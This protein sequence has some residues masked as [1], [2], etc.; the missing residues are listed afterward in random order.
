[1][2]AREE[3]EPLARA[4]HARVDA[5][6]SPHLARRG[7]GVKHPV[8]DFLFGYYSFR[9]A[10]LRRWHPGYGVGL[11][12]VEDAGRGYETVGGVTRVA[13]TVLDSLTQL[14]SVPYTAFGKII[15]EPTIYLGSHFHAEAKAR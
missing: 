15:Y 8:E 5:W 3:W 10:A 7:S 12:G 13:P 4:H 2:L 14:E 11:A 9:P 6:V 1:M